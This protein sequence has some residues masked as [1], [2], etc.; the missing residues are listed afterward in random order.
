MILIATAN[1]S[2]SRNAGSLRDEDGRFEGVGKISVAFSWSTSGKCSVGSTEGLRDDFAGEFLRDRL[3]MADSDRSITGL[4]VG[5]A[6]F[7][8]ARLP[9]LDFR[10]ISS[11]S[12]INCFVG[13]ILTGLVRS[14]NVNF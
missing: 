14:L 7:G 5:E 3:L 1:P 2:L 12:S 10:D 8:E 9:A 11:S 6:F 13:D 4:L